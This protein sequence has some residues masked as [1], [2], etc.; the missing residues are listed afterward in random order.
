MSTLKVPVKFIHL[1]R[2]PFDN[3]ATMTLRAHHPGLRMKA[4]NTG[5]QVYIYILVAF[6]FRTYFTV[7]EDYNM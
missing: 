2:N 5:L 6:V 1:V 7:V 4:Q 3:I